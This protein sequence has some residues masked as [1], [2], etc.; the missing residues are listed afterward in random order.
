[1]LGITHHGMNSFL[2]GSALGK[3]YNF[4]PAFRG[5][6]SSRF[7]LHEFWMVEMEEAFLEG[8]EGYVALIDRL[9]AFVKFFLDDVLCRCSEDVHFLWEFN[10]K[11]DI[12]QV[13]SGRGTED[14]KLRQMR[15]VKGR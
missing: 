4:N 14:F 9:E 13:K 6:K 5:E 12:L 7:H 11:T 8:R 15:V 2:F 1:M 10:K 3:V